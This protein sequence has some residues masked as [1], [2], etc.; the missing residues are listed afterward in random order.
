[1]KYSLF[2]PFFW[3][4]SCDASDFTG[5]WVFLDKNS[6]YTL[7]LTQDNGKVSGHY[8]FINSGGNRIDCDKK[9]ST[10]SG[11][12]DGDASVISFGG[13]GEG[14]LKFLEGKISLIVTNS[15][16]F[17]DFN[18]HIPKLILVKKNNGCS[19]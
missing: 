12:L 6:S 14:R 19:D 8:C 4:L 2:L 1:M 17:D 9:S 10:I 16:P 3:I 5:C 11:V 7:N 13:S 15:Q 18:M